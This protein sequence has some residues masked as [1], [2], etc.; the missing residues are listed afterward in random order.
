MEYGIRFIVG[1]LFVCIFA[2]I[3]QVCKPKQF[4]GIFAAAPSILLAGLAI[5]LYTQGA[6][7]TTLTAEG[8]IAGAVGMIVYCLVATPAIQRF[9][10]LIGSLMSLGGW[11]LSAFAA[12]AVLHMVLGW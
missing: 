3:A 9:K 7:H 10:A 12:F 5:T 1:G 8:A 11:L 2:L 4:A 6:S